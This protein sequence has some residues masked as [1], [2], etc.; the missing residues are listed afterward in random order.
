[1]ELQAYAWGRRGQPLAHALRGQAVGRLDVDQVACDLGVEV[2]RRRMDARVHGLTLSAH[3]VAIN[4]SIDRRDQRFALGHELAHVAVRRGMVAGFEDPRL[5]EVFADTF[6]CELLVPCDFEPS[7][8]PGWLASLYD[9][10]IEAVIVQLSARGQL[11]RIVRST[12]GKVCCGTCGFVRHL[13]SCLCR[14]YRASER[15]ANEL[16]S[17]G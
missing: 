14:P 5:E 12:Q 17:V 1:M 11:P 8:A 7:R 4:S 6:A 10:P 13:Q 2:R 16:V 3:Q 15:L 9:V